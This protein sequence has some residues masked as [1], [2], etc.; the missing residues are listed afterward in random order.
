MATTNAQIIANEALLFNLPL[1]LYTF[2]QWKS[3]GYSVKKGE[4]GHKCSLWKYVKSKDTLTKVE[5]G[6][7]TEIESGHCVMVTAYLFHSG[8]VQKA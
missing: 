7:E 6:T 4:H 3:K 5:N 2:A 1:P 8:Q